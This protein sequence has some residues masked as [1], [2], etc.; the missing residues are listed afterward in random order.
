MCVQLLFS[1][2]PVCWALDLSRSEGRIARLN[3]FLGQRMPHDKTEAN[4]NTV[5]KGITNAKGCC[6]LVS[7][8]ER[9]GVHKLGL[10]GANPCLS[11]GKAE[12]LVGHAFEH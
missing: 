12:H 2:L 7:W 9:Q 4:R 8:V 11:G 6:L 3:L 10:C 1:K 5:S